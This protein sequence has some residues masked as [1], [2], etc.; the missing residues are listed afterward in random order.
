MRFFCGIWFILAVFIHPVTGQETGAVY[1][2]SS[3]YTLLVAHPSD[4]FGKD[5]AD[6]FV[7][8]PTPDK[9]D[10]HD[11]SCK[12][13]STKFRFTPDKNIEN[14]EWTVVTD[15]LDSMQVA[16]RMVAKWFDFND[17]TGTF[18]MKLVAQRGS[19]NAS[20]L[21]VELA[22]ASVR[23]VGQLADAG[24]ELIGHTFVMV[25]DITYVDKEER[26]KM[27]G[28]F[29]LALGSA[30]GDAVGGLDGKNIKAI[31]ESA[32]D[33][34]DQIAGFRVNVSSYLYQLVW[35]DEVAGTFY[36]RHYTDTLS[37]DSLKAQAFRGD[38]TLF[39]LKYVGYHKA[40][41]AKT[42]MNGLEAA[43]NDTLKS[44]MI[45]KVCTRALDEAVT[46]LQRRHEDFRVKVPILKVE[47]YISARIGMKEGITSKSR[48][49][50]LEQS[51]DESGRTHYRRIG[52]VRPQGTIWDNRYMASEERAEGA[53]LTETRFEKVSGGRFYTGMLM[54]EIKF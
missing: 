53:D 31:G 15:F 37:R 9:F 16:K 54:R 39:R 13:M 5:I 49:E 33:I 23:G 50:V 11:L 20:E 43:N 3:L 19:Y 36:E 12:T 40:K 4:K 1:R 35:D 26:G 48:F 45:R 21:D 24:E 7:A 51:V 14:P 34:A 2:R 18:D 6:V 32:K 38:S 17:T 30:V 29:L 52:V 47:P 42:S 46:E 28:E 44:M 25:S 27:W 10:N 8:M 22:R 41:S